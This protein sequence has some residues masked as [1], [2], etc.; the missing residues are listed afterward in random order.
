MS[1]A[2]SKSKS[3]KKVGV[4]KAKAS[5]VNEVPVDAEATDEMSGGEKFLM[6]SKPYWPHALLAVLSIIFASVLWTAY[7][8][9]QT[10]NA[11]QQW[12][13]LNNAMTQA[14]LTNDVTSLKEMADNYEGKAAGNWALQMAGN[15][16]VNRGIDMLAGDRVGGLKMIDQGAESLQ[17]VVDAPATSKSPMLQRRSL[18]MLAYAKEALGKFDDAKGHYQTLLDAAPDSPFTDVAKRGLARVSNPEL[19][20]VYDKF[21]NWEEE[22]EVAPGPLVPDPVKL[23]L[24]GIKLPEAAP[25]TFGGGDFGGGEMKKEESTEPEVETPAAKTEDGEPVAEDKKQPAAEVETPATET[26]AAE[27]PA[28]ETPAT[29]TPVAKEVP[30]VAGGAPA[31]EPGSGEGGQ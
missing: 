6:A 14:G 1:K 4:A 27:T 12:R 25:S 26:P 18:F 24:E 3:K 20:A 28:A 10:E 15:N 5:D 9:M 21:R 30:P 7:S 23:N 29:E 13:D 31:V 19:V 22:T 2:K 8:N 16:E 11:S 17:K